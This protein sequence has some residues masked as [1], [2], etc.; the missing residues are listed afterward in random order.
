MGL[1]SVAIA[2]SLAG[3]V[4]KPFFFFF[5]RGDSMKGLGQPWTRAAAAK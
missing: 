3:L 5:F 4:T 2:H 1:I